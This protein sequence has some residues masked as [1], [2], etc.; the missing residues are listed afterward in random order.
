MVKRKVTTKDKDYT[1][2]ILHKGIVACWVLLLIC[3]VIKLFGGN[4]F[5]ISTNN[6]NLIKLCEYIDGCWLYYLVGF[7]F[8]T[9]T[10][11]LFYKATTVNVLKTKWD[12][13][14]IFCAILIAFS[15]RFISLIAGQIADYIMYLSAVILICWLDKLPIKEIIIRL[16]VGFVLNNAFQLLSIFVKN[17]GVFKILPNYS[18]IQIIFSID[19]IILLLLSYMYV[20][21][22]SIKRRY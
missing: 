16:V 17:L 22:L 13:L 9:S 10:T 1:L 19:Y 15:F 3:F 20:K 8:Y 14:I 4:F 18:L 7:V 2:S 21:R 6:E 5:D 12:N 11:F